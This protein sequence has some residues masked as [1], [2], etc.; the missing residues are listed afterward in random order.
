MKRC[1]TSIVVAV[2]SVV[3]ASCGAGWSVAERELI[4]G[5]GLSRMRVTTIDNHA[6]SVLLRT[7]SK[8]L[9]REEVVASPHFARLVAS[10]IESV[11]DPENAGVG[12]AA[13]QVGVLRQVV[14][15]Q[16]F[17]KEGT[18]FEAYVNPAIVEWGNEWELGE[19]G[20]FRC[21]IEGER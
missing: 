16:R 6:D 19:R 8:P 21:P 7:P 10:M 14:V 9:G 18:P 1:Y 2:W 4:D 12:I 13:P 11:N 15:V 17:D 3:L 5:A 20:A